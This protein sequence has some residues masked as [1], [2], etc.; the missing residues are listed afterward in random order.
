VPPLAHRL[1]LAATLAIAAAQP[2]PVPLPRFADY[3]V[4]TQFTGRP[5]LP[6][7]L[8][9]GARLFRG[10]IRQGAAQGPNFAGHD[11]IATWACGSSCRSLAV[12]DAQTG[13]VYPAPFSILGGYGLTRYPDETPTHAGPLQFQRQSRLLIARGCPEDTQCGSYYYEWQAPHWMLL[14][15]VP[16]S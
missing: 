7:L 1:L 14:R 16:S 3:P 9:P 10:S 11:T 13:Q 2:A 4:S 8:T 15:Y 5:A 12:I 6:Q